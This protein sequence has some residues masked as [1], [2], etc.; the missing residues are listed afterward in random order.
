[1]EIHL[2]TV[3]LGVVQGLNIGLLAVGLVLITG[4]HVVNF[5]R[6]P[7]AFYDPGRPGGRLSLVTPASA[8]IDGLGR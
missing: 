4:R 1:M 5:A 7:C 3:A 8:S 2:S 6:T